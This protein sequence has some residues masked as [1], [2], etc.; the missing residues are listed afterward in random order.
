MNVNLVFIILLENEE[1]ERI[2]QSMGVTISTHNGSTVAHEHNIRNPKVVSKEPH[3]DLNGCHETWIDEPVRQAYDRLFGLAVKKYN[4]KQARP[5]RRIK[6]YYNDICKDSKKHPVYEMVIGIYG[7]N[8]NGTAICSDE[9]G[10]YIMHKFVNDWK[11]RNPNLEMIGAYYHADEPDGQP[12]VHID[13]IPVAH[14]Y[15]KGL[16]IQT[17]LVKAL[18]EQGFC[19]SGKATAQIQ[20]E[21]R[22]NDY[23]TSLCE[24]WNLNVD[25]PKINGR[26]HISTQA[27]KLQSRINELER[28]V[29]KETTRFLEVEAKATDAENRAEAAERIALNAEKRAFIAEQK[30]KE[31]NIKCD[32]ATQELKNVLD[33]KSRASEIHRNI[34]DRDTQSYHI[35]MLEST[36][37]IGN[38]AYQN[39]T[40][41]RKSLQVSKILNLRVNQKEKEIEPLLQQAQD[42]L[43]KAE[44]LRKNNEQEIFKKAQAIATRQISEIMNTIPSNERERM[45]KYMNSLHLPDGST[46]LEHFDE[47]E[48][49]LKQQLQ[50]KTKHKG[51][52]R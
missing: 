46:A 11:E 34:F 9:H 12:H 28:L 26:K 27:L 35:N 20:W 45:R 21:K 48:R 30:L 52:E 19:K 25:H 23:L 38:E 44:E 33:K 39:M 18:E 8:E 1:L 6:S 17:G 51:F 16:E 15:I 32:V 2:V 42:E 31:A 36:R 47:Q 22:E 37:A 5:E 10:K 13:Y 14:G 50:Q 3:I 41:A 4:A 7:K 40:N 24:A 49:Q 29:E 43:L